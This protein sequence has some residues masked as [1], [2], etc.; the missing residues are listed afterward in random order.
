MAEETERWLVDG[1]GARFP[2]GVDDPARESGSIVFVDETWPLAFRNRV[3]EP[4]VLRISP[5]TGCYE[6]ED[7]DG[8]VFWIVVPYAPLTW[9][10]ISP[11]RSPLRP[12][13]QRLYSPFRLAREWLLTT[14]EIEAMCAVPVRRAPLRSAPPGPV[15]RSSSRGSIISPPL[16]TAAAVMHR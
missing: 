7:A 15:T 13:A 1:A 10:W 14:P 5:A 8:I 16:A 12:D 3:G 6:F 4:V 11:F 2:P 9:N